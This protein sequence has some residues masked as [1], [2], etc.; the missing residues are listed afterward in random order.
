MHLPSGQSGPLKVALFWTVSQL[1]DD[2]RPIVQAAIPG[3]GQKA[4]R[5]LK[6]FLDP[7][8]APMPPRLPL[9]AWRF[10][11][12]RYVA[13]V[14]DGTFV[15]NAAKLSILLRP[16]AGLG[17]TREEADLGGIWL[18]GGVGAAGA[19]PRRWEALRRSSSSFG[20]NRNLSRD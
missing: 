16:G 13:N 2:L 11:P 4:M 3:E 5:R 15:I 7:P 8:L 1:V 12:R 17:I 10:T 20:R 18:P 19:F 14:V 6:R 9:E